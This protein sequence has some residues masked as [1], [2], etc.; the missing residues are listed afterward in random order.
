MTIQA[1]NLESLR[2]R[3]NELA[4]RALKPEELQP[5]LRLDAEVSLRELTLER[6][7]ELERL[8]PMGQGNPAFQFVSAQRD[9]SPARCSAWARRSNMSNC[10]SPTAR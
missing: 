6:L 10:G 5:A 2:L 1:E 3:L 7:A 4:R 9:A 8:K